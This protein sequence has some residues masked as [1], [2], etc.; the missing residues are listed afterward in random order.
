MISDVGPVEAHGLTDDQRRLVADLF[1][2]GVLPE[3]SIVEVH[4]GN[5]IIE[6]F[7]LDRFLELCPDLDIRLIADGEL[8]FPI[9]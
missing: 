5:L 1:G 2:S 4:N 7:N 9:T 3:D 8:H 6:H